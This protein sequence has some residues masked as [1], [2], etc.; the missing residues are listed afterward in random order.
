M[1]RPQQSTPTEGE[2][3]V[4]KVLWEHGP[5]TVREVLQVLTQSRKRAYTSVMSLL[6]IM[7]DKGLVK[8]KPQGRAFLYWAHRSREKTL[9]KMVKS[10]LGK[11]FDGSAS[12]LVSRLL[13][14]SK[15]SA[16][17]LEQIRLA[18]DEYEQERSANE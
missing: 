14:E 7:T 2:L 5:S 1:A 13:D 3:E 17:E 16:D 8:R 18:I 9:A 6:N 11:A 12:S 4:L 10:L 15:P